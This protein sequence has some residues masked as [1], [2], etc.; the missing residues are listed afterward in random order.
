MPP[1]VLGVN[2]KEVAMA[3]LCC[4][5]CGAQL[6]EVPGLKFW[7]AAV[8]RYAREHEDPE[9]IPFIAWLH[10]KCLQDMDLARAAYRAAAVARQP[11]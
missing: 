1:R 3:F 6:F 5:F 7:T 9:Y 10:N 4:P 8:T 11:V 2:G